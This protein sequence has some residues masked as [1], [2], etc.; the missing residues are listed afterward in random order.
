MWRGLKYKENEVKDDFK[1]FV[2]FNLIELQVKCVVSAPKRQI[3]QMFKDSQDAPK[4]EQC[5]DIAT[6]P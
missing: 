4:R 1:M 3:K 6:E 5:Y 2:Q